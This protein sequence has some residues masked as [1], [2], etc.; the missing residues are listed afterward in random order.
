MSLWFN[1]LIHLC[2]CLL[3]FLASACWNAKKIIFDIKTFS[4]KLTFFDDFSC[5]QSEINW[6]SLFFLLLF[7]TTSKEFSPSNSILEFP[8]NRKSSPI[9]ILLEFFY[10]IFLNKNSQKNLLSNLQLCLHEKIS[11][12]CLKNNQHNQHNDEHS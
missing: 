11:S 5:H 6:H 2:V 10:G 4:T 12:L 8:K 1:N 7:S 3:D 9:I